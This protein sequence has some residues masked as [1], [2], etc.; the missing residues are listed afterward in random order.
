MFIPGLW[1][2]CVK[3]WFEKYYNWKMRTGY[4]NRPW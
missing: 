3:V 2:H 1:A 4:V